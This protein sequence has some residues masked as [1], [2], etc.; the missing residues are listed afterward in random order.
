VSY[1]LAFSRRALDELRRLP[2]WLQEETLDEIEGIAEAPT[3][4]VRRGRSP[5]SV[6]DFTATR[7]R[8]TH[9]VFMTL[10]PDPPANVLRV[11]TLGHYARTDS[12]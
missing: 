9:Y 11:L 2:V 4:L 6:F 10:E 5:A 12:E 7:P 1:V 3:R 8:E